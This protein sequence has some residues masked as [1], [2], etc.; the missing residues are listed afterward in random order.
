M[1]REASVW[2]RNGERV[3]VRESG[4]ADERAIGDLL[5]GLSMEAR[6]RRFF[7]GGVDVPRL[8]SAIAVSTPDRIGLVALDA[9]GEVVGHAICIELGRGRAEVALEV[10]DRL[11]GEGLGTILVERLAEFAE[12]RGISTLIA[13]VL[14]DNRAMLDVLRDGFDAHVKWS[15][16]VDEVEF[17]AAAWRIARERYSP[18]FTGHRGNPTDA[19]R[20]AAPRGS[21]EPALQRVADELGAGGEP[22]LL[23]DVR[24]MRLDGAHRQEQLLGDLG[25]GVS[26]RDQPQHLDLAL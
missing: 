13:Q 24:A 10:A 8:T 23:L 17:P 21:I 1:E 4:P 25:V 20:Y 5:S 6:T 2:L 3:T 12:R 16:G 14:P 22:E 15:E 19:A 9:S 7:S 26:E 18:M 11:H